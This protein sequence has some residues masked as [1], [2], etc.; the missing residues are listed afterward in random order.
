MLLRNQ[1]VSGSF[2]IYNVCL[3][4][5]FLM[6]YTLLELVGSKTQQVAY[7]KVKKYRKI[8][9]YTYD[10]IVKHL[11]VEVFNDIKDGIVDGYPISIGNTLYLV[12]AQTGQDGTTFGLS[13]KKHLKI[14]KCLK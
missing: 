9:N 1:K 4:S 11:N 5:S 10:K 2:F 14:T 3:G 8:D 13:T 12:D 6:N 7:S